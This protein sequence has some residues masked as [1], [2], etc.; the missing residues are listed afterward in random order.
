MLWLWLLL[1]LL[2]H[3][4]RQRLHSLQKRLSC[5]RRRDVVCS[6]QRREQGVEEGKRFRVCGCNSGGG[7][8]S[9]EG[10]GKDQAEVG[11]LPFQGWVEGWNRAVGWQPGG[12]EVPGLVGT[13]AGLVGRRRTWCV[14]CAEMGEEV[15][16]GGGVGRGDG[17]GDVEELAEDGCCA[18]SE[19]AELLR[20]VL[21]L[22]GRCRLMGVHF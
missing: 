18:G 17:V 10:E 5:A 7:S 22:L 8:G 14:C 15:R 12:V 2:L 6:K 21:G 3:S 16:E 19:V 1:F 20:R 9:G 11:E 4:Q 13:A